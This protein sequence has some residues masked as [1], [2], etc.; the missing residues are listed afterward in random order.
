MK[1]K[2]VK[3]AIVGCGVISEKYLSTMTQKF[4][5]L[6]IVGCCDLDTVKAEAKALKH[7]IQAM[8]M[9][10]ILADPSIELVVNLTTPT[11]HYPVIKQLLNGGKH[12]YTEKVLAVELSQAAELVKIADEKNLYLGAAPDT[13]LGAALQTARYVVESGMLGEITSCYCAMTRDSNILNR[14]FPFTT[15]PGGGI[16]FDV[17][18]YYITALLSILGPV[19]EVSGV[20]RTRDP[21]KEHY[22]L[23]NFGE[24]FQ[25]QCENLMAGTLQFACGTVGNLLFDSNSIFILPEKPAV[26][27]HGTMGIMFMAD[28]NQFGGEVQVILKGNSEPFVMEQSHAFHDECRGLGVA[29]MAWAIRMGRK[30]RAN[31]EMAYHALEVLHGIVKSSETKVNQH[32]QSTFEKTPPIPRGYSGQTYFDFMEESSLAL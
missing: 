8:T 9:E 25:V 15:K 5:I 22:E 30:N 28:P 18:I 17:G 21:E 29:E 1:I 13:F 20:V 4:N 27:L 24:P 16:G 26:V 6:E 10:D 11:A 2:P 31:K 14:A 3:T 19:E 7:G 12:V 32:M 23:E